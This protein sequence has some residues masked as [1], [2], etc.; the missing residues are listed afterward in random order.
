MNIKCYSIVLGLLVCAALLSPLLFVT[1]VS[2]AASEVWVS[3]TYG[4]KTPGWGT[5]HF[6]RIQDAVDAVENGGTVNIGAG[7]Y[8]EN[9]VID[10]DKSLSLQAEDLDNLPVIDGD[11][12]F[13]GITLRGS[14]N[15]VKG[16][17]IRNAQWGI[18]IE[19]DNNTVSDCKISDCYVRM[20]ILGTGNKVTS[21]TFDGDGEGI[22]AGG[23][24]N[25]ISNNTII[26]SHPEGGGCTGI[27]FSYGSYNLIENNMIEN[28]R[29][30]IRL[31]GGENNIIADN[32]IS[33]SWE[34][35]YT[36]GKT[37]N[38]V[39]IRN[40]GVI[41]YAS[42]SNTVINNSISSFQAEVLEY[43]A[44]PPVTPYRLTKSGILDMRELDYITV[45]TIMK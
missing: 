34:P 20:F 43:L 11:G 39:K 27:A 24:Y 33:K 10:F 26:G 38:S 12:N 28:F 31:A 45:P 3:S 25:V 40:A 44:V 7:V 17:N 13:S 30:H 22:M 16:L 37:P 23:D 8:H 19:S 14:D 35:N 2:A 18:W 32:N 1:S 29:A 41:L 36:T 5:T 21:N 42:H 6:D 9:I 4:E 15:L